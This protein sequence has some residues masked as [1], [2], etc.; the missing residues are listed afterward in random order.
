MAKKS[1]IG[2]T[3]LTV[4]K[5]SRAARRNE[6]EEPEAKSLASL[7]RAEKTDTTSAII[8]ATAK[9]NEDLLYIRE[10]CQERRVIIE[11]AMQLTD[12]LEGK[13]QKSKERA[14]QVQTARKS[15][16]DSINALARM[17][18]TTTGATT[19][20]NE[21]KEEDVDE[22]D[23]MVDDFYNDEKDQQQES[24]GSKAANA[25]ALLD[26]VEA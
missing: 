12:R 25:F 2:L 4:S 3:L 16:W 24:S 7:P 19:T 6:I 22:E 17:E 11:R 18:Q 15:N 13:I 23:A 10:D 26:E 1:I 8:R 20:S 9:K 14:R 5:H 21:S